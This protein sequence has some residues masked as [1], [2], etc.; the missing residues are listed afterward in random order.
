N[1][2]RKW[3]EY[4]DRG[5]T[6]WTD[7]MDWAGG[8]PFEYASVDDVVRFFEAMGMRLQRVKPVGPKLGCNEFVFG[9]PS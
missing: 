3:R 2:L 5:M 9:A 1:P 4:G 8:Y 6:A 7:L